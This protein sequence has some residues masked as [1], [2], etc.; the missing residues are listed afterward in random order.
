LI[1]S[2]AHVPVYLD[3]PEKVVANLMETGGAMFSNQ[4]FRLSPMFGVLYSSKILRGSYRY[5]GSC[6]M[7]SLTTAYDFNKERANH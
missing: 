7:K 1:F 4:M 2:L 5:W 3:G 6:Q